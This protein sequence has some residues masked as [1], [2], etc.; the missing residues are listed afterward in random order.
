MNEKEEVK[1]LWK[2]CF[3]DSDEFIAMY[4][5]LRYNDEVS[6]TIRREGR[7]VSALQMIPYPLTFQGEELQAS[8][9]SGACTHPDFRSKGVMKALLIASFEEMA[10]RN[11]PLSFLIPAESGLYHYYARTGYAPAFFRTQTVQHYSHAIEEGGALQFTHTTAFDKEVYDYIAQA[12]RRRTNYVQHTEDDL[13]VV[14]TDLAMSNGNMVVAYKDNRVVGVLFAYPQPDMLKVNELFADTIAIEESLLAEAAHYY[15][16]D[17]ILR[18]N[19]PTGADDE[20]P[21]GMARIV[22]AQ[23]VLQH[24]AAARPTQT[25]YIALVDNE[26]SCNNGFYTIEKGSCTFCKEKPEGSYPI[27]T[28][29]QLSALIFNEVRLYM[30]LMMD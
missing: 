30:S 2:L 16:S 14:L 26:L 9:I 8:Y 22:N 12:S 13:K 29:Q 11:I 6:M 20:L 24:Y 25:M 17:R 1:K 21:F 10:R 19:P 4:F 3:G 18:F 7:I 27:L 15:K 28:I 23:M 5:R